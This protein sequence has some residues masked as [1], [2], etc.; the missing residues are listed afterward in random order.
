LPSTKSDT[1]PPEQ[2][3]NAVVGEFDLAGE[4]GL[5]RRGHGVVG[6]DFVG[7]L[8]QNRVNIALFVMSSAKWSPYCASF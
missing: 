8:G 5:E 6:G 2:P 7:P 1:A 4:N 3:A